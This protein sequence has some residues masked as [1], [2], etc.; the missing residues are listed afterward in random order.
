MLLPSTDRLISVGDCFRREDDILPY[1]GRKF[2]LG[3]FFAIVGAIF[4]SPLRFGKWIVCHGRT[5]LGRVAI[6][7]TGRRGSEA[8]T[9]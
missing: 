8:A 7:Y 9:R 5:V 4:E 2:F 1:G 3:V 6:V